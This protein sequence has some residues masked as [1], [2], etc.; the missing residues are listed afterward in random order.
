[1]VT[2]TVEKSTAEPEFVYVPAP[3]LIVNLDEFT[4]FLA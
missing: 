1:M 3:I 2:G 4:V